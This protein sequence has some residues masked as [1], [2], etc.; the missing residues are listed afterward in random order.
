MAPKF[1]PTWTLLGA[2]IFM[3]MGEWPPLRLNF[4]VK[5]TRS[6][7]PRSVTAGSRKNYLLVFK[8]SPGKRPQ[9]IFISSPEINRLLCPLKSNFLRHTLRYV[10]MLLRIQS[11]I[12]HLWK[13]TLSKSFI[14]CH[15]YGPPK[16]KLSITLSV[17]VC[18][19][20][21]NF[22]IVIHLSGL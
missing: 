21:A 11:N 8:N 15:N 14:L 13:S 22:K 2:S 16:T 9:G 5:T 19:F 12:M 1:L 10:Q 7:T 17:V 18:R 3:S 6:W 4:L 20:F